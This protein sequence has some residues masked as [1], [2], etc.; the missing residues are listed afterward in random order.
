ML[1][2]THN[3]DVA[4]GCVTDDGAG[5]LYKS[6]RCNSYAR[7]DTAPAHYTTVVEVLFAELNL[8]LFTAPAFG[9]FQQL[10]HPE[11]SKFW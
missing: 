9:R 10:L 8:M 6:M 7:P 11:N 5:S 1:Q 3:L 4:S 2:Q